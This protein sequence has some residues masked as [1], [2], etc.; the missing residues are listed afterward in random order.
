MTSEELKQLTSKYNSDR[1]NYNFPTTP[2]SEESIKS[3]FDNWPEL[4]NYTGEE[5]IYKLACINYH[6]AFD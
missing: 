2:C 5:L 6:L 1:K 3:M 4:N